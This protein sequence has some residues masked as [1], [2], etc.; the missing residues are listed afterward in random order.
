[1]DN[2]ALRTVAYA[3]A[4]AFLLVGVVCY[5]AFPKKAPENPIRI[6]FKNAGGNVL[7]DHKGHLSEEGYGIGCA[8]CHHDIENEGDTPAACRSCHKSEEGDAPK[9]ADVLHAQCKDCHN[10]GGSGPVNC[11]ECHTM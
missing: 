6:M 9:S 11:S 7:F 2:K 10:E 5:A 3:M 4:A 8:D 1:M